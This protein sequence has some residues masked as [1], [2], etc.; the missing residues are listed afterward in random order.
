MTVVH[1]GNQ[2]YTALSTDTKPNA[3]VGAEL[4]ETDTKKRAFFDGTTWQY[5]EL[6]TIKIYKIF[7]VGSTHYASDQNNRIAASGTDLVTSVLQPLI[8]AM[9]AASTIQIEFDAADFETTTPILVPGAN[10]N[11]PKI[12]RLKGYPTATRASGTLLHP[13]STF[14]DNRFIIETSGAGP[15][16]DLQPVLYVDGLNI[17]NLH[18]KDKAATAGKINVG[19]IQFEC[20]DVGRRTCNVQNCWFQYCWR[21]L[22]LRGSVWWGRFSNLLFHDANTT[23]VGETDIRLTDGTHVNATNPSPKANHFYHI[24]VKHDGKMNNSLLMRA[25]GYNRFWSY[26]VSGEEYVNS[27]WGLRHLDTL[28]IHNNR[29]WDL[30]TIDIDTT[31]SPD[32][33][34]GIVSLEGSTGV[35]DNHIYGLMT[36]PFPYSIHLQGAGVVNNHIQVVGESGTLATNI[37]DVT[38]LGGGNTIE[39]IGAN[40]ATVSVLPIT[41]VNNLVR[42]I[43]TRAGAEKSGATS[44]ADGGTIAHGLMTTPLWVYVT[45]SIASTLVAITAKTPTTFTVALKNTGGTAGTTQ[46]VYWRAGVYA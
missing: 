10:Q 34:A 46:I 36:T 43:D 8:D 18:F 29:F 16:T 2:Y 33:R 45:P 14:P 32:T 22:E 41:T 6:Q 4:E 1:Y 28:T 5:I 24:T 27:V 38:G 12:V 26:H 40:R 37:N 21:G 7:K 23:F 17:Y 42:I 30:E 9:A 39:V 35:N 13:A 20:D 25:G 11:T 44:V 31:P 3:T 19:G 15:S